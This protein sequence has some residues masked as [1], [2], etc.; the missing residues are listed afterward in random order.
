MTQLAYT[1]REELDE[2]DS[3][4]PAAEQ[5]HIKISMSTIVRV[6]RGRDP[7]D[8]AALIWLGNYAHRER[9]SPDSLDET[10]GVKK[11]AIRAA[12]TDPY[13][14]S[15]PVVE[16]IE[17]FRAV[18]DN[19]LPKLASTRV[20]RDVTEAC[21]FALETKSLVEYIGP[22]RTG[23]TETGEAFFLRHMDKAGYCIVPESDS[24]SD[25][26]FE[27]AKAHG[28][29]AGD[30]KTIGRVKPTIRELYGKGGLELLILDEGHFLWPTNLTLK[31]KRL[32]FVRNLWDRYKRQIGIVVLA[33]PQFALRLNQASQISTRWS[34]E[35]WEGRAVRFM[36]KA[37][38]SDNDLTLIA[39]HH[40]PQGS[41]EVINQLVECGKASNGFSGAMLNALN[42][43][44]WRA[45]Q[46]REPLTVDLLIEAQAQM[47]KGTRIEALAKKGGK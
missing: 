8:R 46:R 1:P 31:P 6:A 32:E 41:S 16:K 27:L 21:Q 47:A 39:R 26:V 3:S 18:L 9:I 34:S 23:K 25:F 28:V 17:S 42:L 5:H 30:K 38:M 7:R 35:Q 43:A 45:K 33:T 2:R 22:P 19:N 20:Y 29:V 10:L 37:T 15:R 44:A 36:G 24:E 12:L 11:T 4:S 40:C 13:S 14:N